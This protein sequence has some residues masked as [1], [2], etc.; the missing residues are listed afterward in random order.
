MI[1]PIRCYS[2]GKLIGNRWEKYLQMLQRKSEEQAKEDR[3]HPENRTKPKPAPEKE[4][5]DELGFTRYC[6]RRMMLTHVDLIEKVM[7]Y[8]IYE[9]RGQQFNMEDEELE[10]MQD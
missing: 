9:K 1:I 2:C 10:D 8:N 4:V 5:L 6:C 3:E 7:N